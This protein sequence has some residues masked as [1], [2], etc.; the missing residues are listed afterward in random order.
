MIFKYGAITLYGVPFQ[1]TSSNQTSSSILPQEQSWPARLLLAVP[2]M[3]PTLP[4]YN[5]HSLL[6]QKIGL[7]S[8]LFARRY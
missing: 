8:S 5:P 4:P 1:G 2:R 3:P 6:A 7:D